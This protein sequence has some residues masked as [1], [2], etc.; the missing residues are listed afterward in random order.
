MGNFA[1]P[2]TIRDMK[3]KGTV[4]KVLNGGKYYV[5]EQKHIKVDG[6][7]KIKSGKMI[8]SIDPL[9]GF[10]PNDNFKKDDAITTVDLYLVI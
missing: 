7:W 5:Y 1:V 6:K 10:I 2:Q 8:G 3:P 9:I 4:V